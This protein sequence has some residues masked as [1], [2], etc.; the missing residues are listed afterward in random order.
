L[1]KKSGA[2]RS[3]VQGI[4]KLDDANFAGTAKSKDCTLILT[5]GDSAKALA[6]SGLSVV[7]RDYYGV[8]PLKGKPLNVREAANNQIM[9]NEEIQN[10]VQILGLKFGMEYT[11]TSSLR[12]GHLMIMADQDYDG[13][14]IKGLLINFL[15][16][17]WPSLLSSCPGFLLEFITPI[18]K[19]TKKNQKHSFFTIPE[20]ES[21]KALNNDGKGWNIKYYKGLGTS[22]GAEGREYFSDLPTHRIEFEWN[23]NKSNIE[24]LD[25]DLN[26]EEESKMG[27]ESVNTKTDYC[28]DL[29]DM[30]F[31]KKRIEE[32]KDWLRKFEVGTHVDYKVEFMTYDNFIN[33]EL[34]LYS[35]A[36]N[37][38]SIPNIM[39]GFKPS[40]R[41]VLY[42]CLRRNLVNEIK[43]A[44]LAGYVSENSGYHH[45]EASL[46]TTI[47]GMAQ[48]FV[49]S[50]NISLLYPSGQFGTRLMGGK[51]ASSSRYIFTRLERITR[52]IFHPNDDPLLKYLDDDGAP[53]E[54]EWYVPVIPM[55]L[56]NGSE[57]IGTGWS[58]NI[59]NYNPSD[60]IDNLRRRIKGEEMLDMHPYYRSFKGLIEEKNNINYYVNGVLHRIMTDDEDE[61]VYEITELPIKVWT[62]S[63][64]EFL[65]KNTVGMAN[66]EKGAFIK[67]F[68]EY[69]TETNVHFIVT[70]HPD[71]RAKFYDDANARKLFKIDSSLSINN[72]HLFDMNNE[73]K[74]FDSPLRI[75]DEYYGVR[76]NFYKKRKDY[77]ISKLDSEYRMLLNKVKFINA[78]IDGSLVLQNRKRY[79]LLQTLE[80]DGYECFDGDAHKKF[81]IGGSGRKSKSAGEEN[82]ND[83]DDDYS[84]A[85]I[86][87]G[88]SQQMQEVEL[89]KGYDYL[90][91][92]R[93]W[94]LTKEKVDQLKLHLKSKKEELDKLRRTSIT[95]LWLRDLDDLEESFQAYNDALDEEA[96]KL[97]Q[98]RINHVKKNTKK[99]SRATGKKSKVD[100]SVYVDCQRIEIDN[101]NLPKVELTEAKGSAL[102][103]QG[104]LSD[105][106]G[107]N[108]TKLIKTESGTLKRPREK[109]SS[110]TKQNL[111]R[112]KKVGLERLSDISEEEGDFEDDDDGFSADEIKPSKKIAKTKKSNGS[113]KHTTNSLDPDFNLIEDD[114]DGIDGQSLT[115]QQ[116]MAAR[117]K[118]M[119]VKES[120]SL[121]DLD[122][123]D[124]GKRNGYSSANTATSA[125]SGQKLIQ[126]AIFE[127]GDEE[128]TLSKKEQIKKGT[129]ASSRKAGTKSPLKRKANS[130]IK[131][132]T[133]ATKV[134][135]KEEK[136]GKKSTT[137]KKTGAKRG[138]TNKKKMDD[139]D[140]S[141][142]DDISEK[143]DSEDAVETL[144]STG[145][146]SSSRP[147][148]ATT[149]A[150]KKYNFSDSEDEEEEEQSSEGNDE[151]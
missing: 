48:N 90:L 6:I 68:K 46:N 97:K 104:S 45:G 110:K 140:D 136:T 82:A 141:Y 142:D 106:S 29:I 12:Y 19:A 39:D 150:T 101:V 15:H 148:R 100:A 36:D 112:M 103:G 51:D 34:I 27:I 111:K 28:G 93:L 71:H 79:E 115:L 128:E 57:G 144:P 70:I 83:S 85:S 52:A 56:V 63:Y 95:D 119:N 4:S 72:M 109:T 87:S 54:P 139:S 23:N 14:H 9:K 49:G 13:S 55:V 129:S 67:E 130:P 7:G 60:V 131:K 20:Y 88:T 41:K 31:S 44:Q 53:I 30:A 117:R 8:F 32:R 5:E 58:T 116:K 1:K 65:E 151:F 10:I 18:I 2:K 47:V 25:L 91:S 135:V 11:N 66:E 118:Q 73:I 98:A 77:L 147:K 138:K 123:L 108:V 69:H 26:D 35:L 78:F 84:L 114:E 99:S 37:V 94:S 64:K 40:Q 143:E 21:W 149:K 145:V 86:T 3:R 132:K 107:G 61:R 133:K 146:A 42:A 105:G 124:S 38:R 33:Q 22:S 120:D 92:M 16:H 137:I 96:E 80:K 122:I 113:K 125:S 127:F 62:Q 17:F 50:N 43:V 75:M 24:N 76:L 81:K 74:R 89:V 59:P 126:E 121:S 102:R 134:S